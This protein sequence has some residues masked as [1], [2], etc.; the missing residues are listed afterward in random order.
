[1]SSL[2]SEYGLDFF[3]SFLFDFFAFDDADDADAVGDGVGVLGDLAS[4]LTF[5]FPESEE[6]IE[7]CK[8]K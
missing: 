8:W 5:N 1:M 2:L 4:D 3:F 6:D 7:T